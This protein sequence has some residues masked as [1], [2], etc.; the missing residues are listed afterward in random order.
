MSAEPQRLD[1]RGAPFEGSL[2]QRVVAHLEDGGLVAYPTETVYGFGAAPDPAGVAAVARLKER[3]PR[4]P[5]IVLLPHADGAEELAWTPEARELARL[6]WPGALTLV[7]GD[8]RG[9]FPPGIRSAEGTVAVRVS[10]HPVARALL[11]AWGRPLISTSVN[12]P[13]QGAAHSGEE[14]LAVSRTLGADQRLLVLDAGTLPPSEPS[15]VV[16]CTAGEPRVL[17]HGSV[18]LERLRCALPVRGDHHG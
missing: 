2:V 6:F 15:T 12:A 3:E 14:A 7:L 17:R 10:P 16:D 1:L 9:R 11:E 8:P 13:G 4:K 5:F 18:P